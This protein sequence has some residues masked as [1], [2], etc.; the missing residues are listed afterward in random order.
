MGMQHF[1]NAGDVSQL[2]GRPPIVESAEM[3]VAGEAF[4]HLQN[5][6][7]AVL[8]FPDLPLGEGQVSSFSIQFHI[9][10]FPML[11]SR[12]VVD[13]SGNSPS[14][15]Q[16]FTLSTEAPQTMFNRT[17]KSGKKHLEP[18]N[19]A[20]AKLIPG[21]AFSRVCRVVRARLPDTP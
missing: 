6:N 11:G 13:S 12:I 8:E 16:S 10:Q 5:F 3:F 9:S 18:S 17:E 19:L 2:G 20:R 15:N 1:L 4:A 7:V 21:A 14:G